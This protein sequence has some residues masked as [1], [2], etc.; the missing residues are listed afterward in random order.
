MAMEDYEPSS[1]YN[2]PDGLEPN[3]IPDTAPAPTCGDCAHYQPVAD[4]SEL[5]GGYCDH[6]LTRAVERWQAAR[7]G[8]DAMAKRFAKWTGEHSRM[9]ADESC[10]DFEDWNEG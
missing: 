4:N 2:L 7:L 3:D 8:A 6:G 9:D 5:C 10:E 1:G